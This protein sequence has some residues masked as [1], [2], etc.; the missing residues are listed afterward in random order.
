MLKVADFLARLP[1]EDHLILA[2]VIAEGLEQATRAAHCLTEEGM[3][4]ENV[5]QLLTY[6]STAIAEL[7]AARDLLRRR[8]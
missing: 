4:Q 8:A 6:L 5:V 1:R 7:E 3:K 2:N